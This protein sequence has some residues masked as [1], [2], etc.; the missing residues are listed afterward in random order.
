MIATQEKIQALVGE[1]LAAAN[2]LHGPF[3]SAHEGYAVI[4]EEVQ[5]A[6]DELEAAKLSL[7]C[8]WNAIRKDK[9]ADVQ[10][11]CAKPIEKVALRLAGEAV[12]VAAM[13]RKFMEVTSA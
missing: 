12:Q 9:A 13:A 11:S 1:E 10:R 6:E 8:L 2:A 4:L 3:A 7:D 5:E